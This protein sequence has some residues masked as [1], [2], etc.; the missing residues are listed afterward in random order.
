MDFQH[1]TTGRH[2][3]QAT[4]YYPVQPIPLSD[5]GG[6]LKYSVISEADSSLRQFSDSLNDVAGNIP[7]R[8]FQH[9]VI[10]LFHNDEI[11]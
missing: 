8:H 10:V 4:W 7:K 9:D 6:V 2:F 3:H 5:Y 11:P 1:R